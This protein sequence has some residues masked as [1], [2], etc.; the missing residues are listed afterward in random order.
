MSAG[1]GRT[2]KVEI[3]SDALQHNLQ[4][5][6]QLAPRSKIIAVIKANAYGHGVHSVAH[7]LADADAFALAMCEEALQLR[8]AGITRPM[9]VLHGFH[10]AD[11]LAQ[12]ASQEISAV[13]HHAAQVVLLENYHGKPIDIWLKLDTG[14]HRLGFAPEA[15][16]DI[17]KRLRDCSAVGRI[18]LMSHFANA[19]DTGHALNLKQ[20]QVFTGLSQDSGFE[21]SMANSAALTAIP[22]S[23]FDWV[24]PG[25]ML[26]GSSSLAGQSAQSLALKPVMSF[27]APVLAVKRLKAGDSVGYGS[28]WVC[29]HDTHMAC[30]AAGY[31]DGYPRHARAGTPVVINGRRCAL[32]GRVSMDSIC[33]ELDD[34]EVTPGDQA[35]LWGQQLCVDEV[36]SCAETIS[37]ELLCQAGNA[38]RMR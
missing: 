11:E 20:L 6:R 14:M 16:A 26:Y 9:M 21:C 24:R 25:I 22:Q 1:N 7:A 2:A 38:A 30:V 36:A 4:R 8:A 3:D 18:R 17:V 13:V 32:I 12:L 28:C 27:T 29:Q 35:E 23:H 10:T 33:V 5:V 15:Y 31:A 19:D 34:L 37:Y